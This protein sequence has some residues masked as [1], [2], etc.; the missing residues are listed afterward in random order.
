[1]T[2]ARISAAALL[3]LLAACGGSGNAALSKSFTYGAATAPTS[4]ESSA[5]STAQSNLSSTRS[6]STQAD[7]T[8][9]L[10]IVEFADSIAAAALGSAAIPGLRS[11]T[12]ISQPLREATSL[13]TCA[14]VAANTVT[15]N[16]CTI[17]ESGFNLS[18]GGTVSVSA[19]T[20][21]WNINGSFSGAEQ[22]VT[23]NITHH[24]S[25]TF[26]VTD[27]KVT[28]NS[29]SEFGGN[30]SGQG[31]SVSFGLATAAVVDLT[32][33]S[34]PSFCVT[35]GTVEVK[36]VWTAKP[37]GASGAAFADAGIKLSWTGCNALTVAH[38]N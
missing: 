30:I 20:V 2:I 28:G 6:F 14:T 32:Y 13:D 35:S 27:T 31:Q 7:A 25:G 18:F 11:G 24:Q 12:D 22:G 4:Q 17:S 1:M 29:V 8:K 33:Q 16:N 38:S 3:A 37:N 26:T 34:S 15:F 21:T 36:R 9:G 23:F 5:A 10:A 19:N